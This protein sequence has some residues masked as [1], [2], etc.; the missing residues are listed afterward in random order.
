MASVRFTADDAERAWM[1]WAANCGPGSIAAALDM[2]LDEIRPHLG[3]FERKRYTNPTL[4]WAIL[5][6]IGCRWR[7]V[8]PPDGW[9]T[10]GLVRVQWE[11]P[12]SA[13]GV[14][15]HVAYRHTHWVA[16]N[17]RDRANIGVFDINCMESGGWIGADDWAA[18]VVPWILKETVPRASGGWHFT[19]VVEIG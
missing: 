4:M 9:P 14:P 5:N 12:W 11:G 15:P 3:D 8:K 1:V 6:S 2:T 19:H 18:E 10:F 7:L 13:T 16:A 17:A